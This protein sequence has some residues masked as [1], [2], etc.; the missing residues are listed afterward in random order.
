MRE[1]MNL[2]HIHDHI[3]TIARQA[4]GVVMQYYEQPIVQSTK[5]TAA[6]VVTTADKATEK[7][8]VAELLEHYP[9]HHIVGEEGGGQ[10]ADPEIAEYFWYV[11]PIDGTNNFANKIPH[12]CTCIALTDKDLNPLVGVVYDPVRDELFSAIRGEGAWCD[13]VAVYVS[14][15]DD[16][17]RSVV[18]SGFPYSKWTNDDD[19]LAEWGRFV[20]RV[21]G[22][23]RMGSAAL[24]SAYVACGRFE[25]YW[26][27]Y[28]N[29]WD[30]A[31]AAL[32]V[33]E[34][35]G[36]VTNYAGET[37]PRYLEQQEIVMSNGH[38]HQE[39]V[40]LLAHS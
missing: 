25:G 1:Y 7:V 16:L 39:M 29:A 6:D 13:G 12:F 9:H 4:G 14:K 24:D 11:D 2:Q 19:N 40:T 17:S 5:S 26:E 33:L 22:V 23:R 35:G 38:I 20:K 36:T 30:I 28:I 21:R 31:A 15:T 32:L 3:I 37:P 34:A 27:R 18:S 8:I 10:G